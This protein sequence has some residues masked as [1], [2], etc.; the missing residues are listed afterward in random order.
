MMSVRGLRKEDFMSELDWLSYICTTK[1]P[2]TNDIMRV[3][4]QQVQ[5][6]GSVGGLVPLQVLFIIVGVVV[7]MSP[8][9]INQ[10]DGI[11]SPCGNK[12]SWKLVKHK[13]NTGR[14]I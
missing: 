3:C 7:W 10:A 11:R 8:G 6:V 12:V 14:H 4:C 5:P 13:R 9:L 2:V 1:H